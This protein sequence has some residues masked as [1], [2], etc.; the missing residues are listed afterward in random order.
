MYLRELRIRNLKLLRDFSLSFTNERG[1]PRMWTVIVG[2]NGTCKTSILQAVALAAAGARHVNALAGN[3]VALR[4]RR[5]PPT[6]PPLMEV[7]ATFG[8]SAAWRQTRWYPGDPG[9]TTETADLRVNSNVK[10]PIEAKDLVGVSA[11]V[12][13]EA[14]AVDPIV[15]ARSQDAP[16]W[17]VAGYGVHRMLPRSP[18]MQPDLARPSIDRLRP[19]FQPV[20]LIGTAFANILP[21]DKAQAYGRVLKKALFGAADL[22]PGFED[23][24]LRGQG[25]IAH[26]RSLQESHRFVQSL[27]GGKLKLAASWLSHGYQS[28]IAWIADL[29]GHILWEAKPDDDMA[30]DE[31]EG[32]VLIDEIDLHLHPSWQ[33]MLIPA[34]KQTFPR[35]QFVVTTHSPLTLVGL[36]PDQDEIVRLDIDPSSGDVRVLDLKQGQPHEPD[37]RLMT[38]TEIYQEYFGIEKFHPARLGELLR[39]HRY[40]AADPN[41]GAEQ[42]GELT[43]IEEELRQEGVEP[44][45]P[46]V[47]RVR[48]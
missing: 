46:R 12:D 32:L 35:L 37:P 30:P 25:G 26:A 24:E 1:E 41:R 17:F 19:L 45:F 10:L 22:L 9:S 18:E 6:D 28:T 16:L 34:L 33:R 23:M 14:G 31:M 2:E 43:R 7:E 47:P 42:D 40:L 39:R 27:P 29:V 4:D 15:E 44:D 13:A 11:Y 3:A 8:L 20:D 5:P 36:R 21:R 48:S 38:G